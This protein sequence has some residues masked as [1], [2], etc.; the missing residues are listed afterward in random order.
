M[1]LEEC[2]KDALEESMQSYRTSPDYIEQRRV[3]AENITDFK[4]SLNPQQVEKFNHILDSISTC[5]ADFT[6][7]A[8]VRGVVEGIALRGKVMKQ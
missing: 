4:K 2:M 6:S 1:E 3:I 7:E 5:D 8:Y